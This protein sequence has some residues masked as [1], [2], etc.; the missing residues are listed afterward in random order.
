MLPCAGPSALTD[1]AP[2][3]TAYVARRRLIGAATAIGRR[4]QCRGKSRL[5]QVR[6]SRGPQSHC[7]TGSSSTWG[8]LSAGD[9]FPGDCFPG[10]WPWPSTSGAAAGPARRSSGAPRPRAELPKPTCASPRQAQTHE[11]HAFGP[12][13]GS[14]L[15]LWGDPQASG[16][17]GAAGR[18]RLPLSPAPPPPAARPDPR[19]ARPGSRSPRRRRPLRMRRD[20]A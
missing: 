6:F 18:R 5:G 7:R 16:A 8:A 20:T 10:G 15:R 19:R 12:N 13:D 9:G 17:V 3:L 2:G 1:P 4:R 14:A 11:T